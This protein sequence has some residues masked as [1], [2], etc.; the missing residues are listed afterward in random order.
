LVLVPV[1]LIF[2]F[3][4]ISPCGLGYWAHSASSK[5][6][7]KKRDR[8]I[9]ELFATTKP[10]EI[11]N[12]SGLGQTLTFGIGF[13]IHTNY[14]VAKVT[15]GVIWGVSTD[16]LKMLFDAYLCAQ[17]VSWFYDI[18]PP[19]MLTEISDG[20]LAFLSALSNLISFPL[21]FDVDLTF[22]YHFWIRM[23]HAMTNF[24]DW[25]NTLVGVV[26]V[27]CKGSQLPLYLLAN[28]L[29]L[30]A[31][32]LIIESNIGLSF[33]HAVHEK[34]KFAKNAFD[35]ACAFAGKELVKVFRLV[36]QLCI[37]AFS[38]SGIFFQ[39]STNVCD[40]ENAFGWGWN[41]DW[42]IAIATKLLAGIA[43]PL[44]GHILLHTFVWGV[45]KRPEDEQD[46]RPWALQDDDGA[47]KFHGYY[48][49]KLDAKPEQLEEKA[50]K[51]LNEESSD[52]VAKKVLEL[53]QRPS[54]R[55]S[56]QVEF[57]VRGTYLVVDRFCATIVVTHLTPRCSSHLQR[58]A[59]KSNMAARRG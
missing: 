38:Y 24:A 45:G 6:K 46:N 8:M 32:V 49:E 34:D 15:C 12:K 30:C 50:R 41:P 19:A 36:L 55:N 48:T 39:S 2:I 4:M 10:E 35:E 58:R 40:E 18:S 44:F 27:T 17:S 33:F 13:F 20:F 21:P 31:V 26:D 1:L 42:M 25:A 56:N 14:K 29:L 57:A 53:T 5:V 23:E 59:S 16:L 7:H 22:F 43:A 11:T 52:P 51:R 54:F 9:R 37:S 47:L 28:L 3:I